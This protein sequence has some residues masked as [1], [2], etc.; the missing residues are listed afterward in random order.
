MGI[1]F[2][3]LTFVSFKTG[4]LQLQTPDSRKWIAGASEKRE[5][6]ASQQCADDILQR[7]L[8]ASLK[9]PAAGAE[10]S[11]ARRCL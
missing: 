10:S 9:V 11:P 1:Q 6:G 4:K 3:L 2:H 8:G 5:G 7:L